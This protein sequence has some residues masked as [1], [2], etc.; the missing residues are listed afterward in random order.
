MQQVHDVYRSVLGA[1]AWAALIRA[2][3]VVY[4]QALQRRAHALRI[5]DC[6]RCN[7]LIRYLHKFTCGLRSIKLS[8]PLRP[9]GFTD[10]AFMAL[11]G[12]SRGLALGSLATILLQ[13]RLRRQTP[14]QRRTCQLSRFHC[15]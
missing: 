13:D 7:L 2:D 9:L 10:V 3:L 5:V 15:A 8:H 12:D 11:V 4:V 6:K 1:A 14:E